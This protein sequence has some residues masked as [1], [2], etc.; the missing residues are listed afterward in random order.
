ME[1]PVGSQSRPRLGVYR[2][3]FG[4]EVIRLLLASLLSSLALALVELLFAFGIQSLF[5]SLGLMTVGAVQLPAWIPNLGLGWA[6][7]V[8]VILATLRT[9]LQ[10]AQTT[11]KG[12]SAEAV[13]HLQRSRIL[14]WAFGSSSASTSR[15]VS[16]FNEHTNAIGVSIM[17]LQSV[18]VSGTTI[19]VI[20]ISMIAIAPVTT[21]I[22][23]LAMLVLGAVT[24]ALGDRILSS[25]IGL[26]RE[27]EST[28]RRLLVSIRNLLLIQIYGTQRLEERKAQSSLVKYRM[29]FDTY[30]RVSGI[31]FALPSFLGIA[32]VCTIILFSHMSAELV[33]GAL[34]SYLYLLMRF[35]QSVSE[36]SK[37]YSYVVLNKPLLDASLG[38]WRDEARGRITPNIPLLNLAAHESGPIGWRL[39]DVTFAY[40]ES[41]HPVIEGLHLEVAP[42]GS[43]MLRGPSGAGKTT[44]LLLVLGMLEPDAGAI[45]VRMTRA[46]ASGAWQPLHE[47]RN[48]VLPSI[49]YVGP[50]SFLIEGTIRENVLYGLHLTTTDDEVGEALRMAECDFVQQ[51]SLGMHHRITEQG[52]GLSAG[53]KQRI[54]LARALLRKP[55][56]LV[57]DEATANLDSET[58]ERIIRTLKKL[59]G[60]VTIIAVTHRD[61]MMRIADQVVALK[62]EGRLHDDGP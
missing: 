9:L 27:W 37:Q 15:T 10:W 48:L 24:R 41:A 3:F 58:E 14:H 49:G 42:G 38:W 44:V 31:R 16:L 4:P 47:V 20:G 36:L 22:V 35:V 33:A 54:A 62:G 51:L 50:E 43:V 5:A 52:Q 11:L 60:R 34:V 40:P 8:F 45:D 23:L 30:H 46:G 28:N 59:K 12:L 17:S 25:A 7:A 26:K 56:A 53:Q 21:G 32:A 61:A 18:L 19:G 29:H 57:L 13:K 55:S 39:R 2:D 6:L 1:S